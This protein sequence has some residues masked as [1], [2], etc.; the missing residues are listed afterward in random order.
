MTSWGFM[1]FML[2]IVNG[3]INISNVILIKIGN[4]NNNN[5]DSNDNQF[6]NNLDSSSNTQMAGAN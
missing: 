1:S 3:V 4:R 6:N 2:S 5:N